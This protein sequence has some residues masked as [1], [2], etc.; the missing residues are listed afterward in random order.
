[1]SFDPDTLYK[2]LPAVYRIRDLQQVSGDTALL[3]QDQHVDQAEPALPLLALM[4]VL[5]EQVAVLE[6]NLAQLY[7]DQFI[8]TCAEWAIPYIGNLVGYQL[9]HD[10]SSQS[11]RSEVANTIRYRKRKGTVTLLEQLIRDVTGWDAHVVEYFRLLAAT[12]HLQRPR[13]ENHLIDLRQ[14]TSPEDVYPHTPFERHM[15]TVDVRNISSGSGRYNI[16]NI[17]VFLW[18]LNAYRLTHAP[19]IEAPVKDRDRY[20]YFFNPLGRDL[21]LFTYPQREDELT[22]LAGPLAVAEPI[23]RL[24]LERAFSDYYGPQKSLWLTVTD[25]V[26]GQEIDRDI[27]PDRLAQCVQISQALDSGLTAGRLDFEQLAALSRALYTGLTSLLDIAYRDLATLIDMSELVYTGLASVED[28]DFQTLAGL[29]KKSEALLNG[30]Q[31]LQASRDKAEPSYTFVVSDLSDQRGARGA[32]GWKAS[33]EDMIAIDPVLG[34]IA[35][36][37]PRSGRRKR[38]KPPGKVRATF[39]YGFSA[40]MGGGEYH[41]GDSFQDLEALDLVAANLDAVQT[42]LDGIAGKDGTVE[43]TDSGRMDGSLKISAGENQRIE[44]RAANFKRPLLVLA[45]EEN[46]MI[47][48][49][50]EGSEVTING[51]VISH[52][53]LHVRGKLRRLALVH[54]TLVPGREIDKAGKAQGPALPSLICDSPDTIVEIDHTIAGGLEIRGSARVAIADSIIDAGSA[55]GIAYAGPVALAST[56]EDA[57]LDTLSLRNCTIIGRVQTARLELASNTIFYAHYGKKGA[58]PVQVE[59]QQ[60]GCVRFSYLPA[61]AQAPLRRY[62]CV[63]EEAGATGAVGPHFTSLRYGDAGYGQLSRRTGDAIL[64]GA[65]DKAE[66]GAFHDLFQPQRAANLRLRLEENLRFGFET[67]IFYRT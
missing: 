19:A 61:G 29:I 65:D 4:T 52:G 34:R 7:D 9:P 38:V 6:E 57:A 10:T 62:H 15:H 2:L 22:Q 14:V 13:R 53:P 12:Q 8:E 37:R 30:L 26:D 1:M 43:I 18:R 35:F 47:I 32:I 46:G 33:P 58:R 56:D 50:E 28:L 64:R 40:D 39:S 54:C 24:M 5:A 21:Q 49:G 27:L 41:R 25:T 66:M 16:P 67:G 60:E 23:S 20:L 11:L 31:A 44:L 59:R 17:G 51:L 3:G 36:P 48:E 42:A 45:D 55:R 63:Q